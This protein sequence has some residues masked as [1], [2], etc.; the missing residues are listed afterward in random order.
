MR[1][2]HKQVLMRSRADSVLTDLGFLPVENSDSEWH[3]ANLKANFVTIKDEKWGFNWYY[4]D[5]ILDEVLVQRL[6]IEYDS[7]QKKLQKLCSAGNH[8][9]LTPIKKTPLTYIPKMAPP[10]RRCAYCGQV[11]EDIDLTIS[12]DEFAKEICVPCLEK[13]RL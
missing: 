12:D 13:S 1:K 2:T 5:L 10:V 7:F 6:T 4:L 3:R 11:K 8:F 9:T